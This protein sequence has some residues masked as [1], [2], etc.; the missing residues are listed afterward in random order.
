MQEIPSGQRRFWWYAVLAIAFWAL[1]FGVWGGE[2]TSESQTVK[3]SWEGAA[4]NL[5]LLFP[6]SRGASW[7]RYVLIAEGIILAVFVG[8]MGFPPFGPSFGLLAL[9]AG[10]QIMLLFRGPLSLPSSRSSAPGA[11]SST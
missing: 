1:A 8:S 3:V 7:A 6:L 5:L 9:V 10:A 4:V 11:P 2:A